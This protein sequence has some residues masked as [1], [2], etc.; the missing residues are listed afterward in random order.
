MIVFLRRFSKLHKGFK[1]ILEDETEEKRGWKRYNG[2]KL[3][4]EEEMDQSEDIEKA[5]EKVMDYLSQ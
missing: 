3:K 4:E 2:F 1:I 5:A